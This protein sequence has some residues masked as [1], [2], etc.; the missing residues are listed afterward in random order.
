MMGD[1][2]L[3]LFGAIKN[4]PW[5]VQDAVLGALDMREALKQYN[6]KLKSQSLPELS[7]GMGI[8]QGEVL[9]G[10]MGN[11]EL[12]KFG[13]VGDTINVASRVE[14][15]TRMHNVDLLI[16]EQVRRQLDNRFKLVKMPAMEVK[17]K[18]EWIVTYLVEGQ[19]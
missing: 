19:L 18:K 15:L 13:V 8:H 7:I 5:Q 9:A 3:A 2:L 11:Y 4:N 10:V 14:G 12:S 1:G 17:G 6:L 16:T